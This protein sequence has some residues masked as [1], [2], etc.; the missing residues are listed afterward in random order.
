MNCLHGCQREQQLLLPGK[1]QRD[2][3][4]FLLES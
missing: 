4:Y 3:P 1:D 2:V